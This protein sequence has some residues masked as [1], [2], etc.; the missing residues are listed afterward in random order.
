MH[1]IEAHPAFPQIAAIRLASSFGIKVVAHTALGGPGLDGFGSLASDPLSIAAASRLSGDKN[2]LGE[3][4][5][6]LLLQWAFR[7]GT[8]VV[9]SSS[10]PDRMLRLASVANTTGISNAA[11]DAAALLDHIPVNRHRRRVNP[12]PFV[13]LF[14]D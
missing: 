11:I 3:Q 8:G 10:H 2:R 9:V 5:A 13:F 4:V 12:E 1:Q 14:E 6:P 7:R